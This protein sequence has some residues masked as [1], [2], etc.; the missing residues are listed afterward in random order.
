[1]RKIEIDNV[2][3]MLEK[4][5]TKDGKIGGLTKHAGKNVVI[6]ITKNENK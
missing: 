1:M 5:V 6:I 2:E 3:E 4:T